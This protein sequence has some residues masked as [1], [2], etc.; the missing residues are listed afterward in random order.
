MMRNHCLSG[1]IADATWSK[2]FQFLTYK[3]EWYGKNLVRI[4][5]F[6]PSSKICSCGVVNNNLTLADREW[7]CQ[8]CGAHHDRDI[9]AARNIK[10]FRLLKQNKVPLE[11]RELTPMEIATEVASM[12]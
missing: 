9:L 7:I 4:G 2:F 6:E 1:Y 8:V 10:H 12:K 11:E 5:R 3:C